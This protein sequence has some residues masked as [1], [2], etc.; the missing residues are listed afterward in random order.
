[1]SQLQLYCPQYRLER[2][3]FSVITG[4]YRDLCQ[5]PLFAL[6]F[7]I[8]LTNPF[9]SNIFVLCRDSLAR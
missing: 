1:M 7:H 6:Y 3:N 8:Q 5:A 9:G 2:H 4:I